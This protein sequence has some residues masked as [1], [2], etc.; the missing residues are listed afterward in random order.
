MSGYDL[1]N[2]H[3]EWRIANKSTKLN[4]GEYLIAMRVCTMSF[5]DKTRGDAGI[6]SFKSYHFMK[7]DPYTKEWWH[8]DGSKHIQNKGKINPD[9]RT[10]WYKYSDND[11]R[12]KCEIFANGKYNYVYYNT[13][14]GETIK[15]QTELLIRHGSTEKTFLAFP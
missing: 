14:S 3:I 4:K 7:Q 10:S 12:Y 8:K 1:S 9:L 6:V 11:Y 2:M 5:H 15:K 13:R